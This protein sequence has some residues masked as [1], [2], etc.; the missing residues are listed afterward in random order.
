MV[1]KGKEIYDFADFRL[2]VSERLL[3][4]NGKRVP[5][6]D[7]PFEVLCVLVRGNGHLVGKDELLSS[8]WGETIVEEN[9]LDKSI[10]AL[11]SVLGQRKGKQKF[12]ETVRGHGYR[13]AV[14][15]TAIEEQTSGS[16]ESKPFFPGTV[17]HAA[18]GVPRHYSQNV[19]ALAEWQSPETAPALSLEELD[20]PIETGNPPDTAQQQVGPRSRHLFYGAVTFILLALLST[21]V[22]ATYLAF[23]SVPPDRPSVAVLPF[24]NLNQDVNAEYLSDSVTENIIN[25]L[26]RL[27]GLR[28]MSRNSAF[29]FRNDQSDINKVTSQLGVEH[30]VTGD[31]DQSNDKLVVHV[32]LI[33]RD[34][35]QT[36]GKQYV[37]P[38]ADL[39][40]VQDQIARDVWRSLGAQLTP[41]DGKALSG[42]ETNDPEAYQDYL[43]AKYFNQQRT[44]EAAE[45]AVYYF[46]RAI[47]RDPSFAAPYAEL[48]AIFAFDSMRNG[49]P[50]KEILVKAHDYA[51][52]AISLNDRLSTAH[53]IYGYLLYNFDYNFPAAEREFQ[54]ALELDPSDASA[55]ETYAGML[56]CLGRHQESMAVISEAEALDPLSASI[57]G[58]KGL[59][60]INA[61]NLDDAAAAFNA[62]LELDPNWIQGHY[63]LAIVHQ[64]QGDYA[65]SVEE[66]AKILEISGN[67]KGAEFVRES[68]AQGGWQGFLTAITEDERAPEQFPYALAGFYAALGH[69]DKALAI[70]DDLYE[71]GSPS[72]VKINV[73][74]HFASLRSEPRF[75]QILKRL[76]LE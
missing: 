75:S 51:L 18:A 42:R 74:A 25:G 41:A 61:G 50:R 73:D 30:V 65:A 66:R 55:R 23:R 56:S 21:G 13:F 57:K 3:M 45:K 48:A 9:N 6:A 12:I 7:K 34:G 27:P 47:E 5:I 43:K 59:S 38:N 35:S 63:G 53:E 28:V 37:H 19:V 20:T 44:N 33:K 16:E 4:R 11:R 2:D 36:W 15:V 32:R 52:K 70:I 40:S 22:V 54:R 58:S 62:A 29:V 71:R 1:A 72:I 31:I 24:R 26:A 49:V 64:M 14:D 17:S 8:V 39:E 46:N 67:M 69:N 76:N 10:S 68:F 60:L